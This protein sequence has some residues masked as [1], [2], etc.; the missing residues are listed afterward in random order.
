LRFPADSYKKKEED[1]GLEEEIDIND[2]ED[3]D[4]ED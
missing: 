4:D 1:A 2:L 3:T